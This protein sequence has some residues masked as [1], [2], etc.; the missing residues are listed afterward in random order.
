MADSD[1]SAP[2]TAG[3][4]GAQ[5]P[6]V[7]TVRARALVAGLASS[8]VPM[9]IREWWSGGIRLMFD[10]QAGAVDERWATI[11]AGVLITFKAM[12]N[13]QPR[14]VTIH[15]RIRKRDQNVIEAELLAIDTEA[16]AALQSLGTVKEPAAPAAPPAKKAVPAAPEM[17]ADAIAALCLAAVRQ[18]IPRVVSAY[19][20]GL[21]DSL[22]RLQ[23]NGP[24]AQEHKRYSVLLLEFERTRTHLEHA[25]LA[26]ALPGVAAYLSDEQAASG[27]ML[28]SGLS[29]L[30]SID[31]RATLLVTEAVEQVATRLRTVWYELDQ[32][33]D[34]LVPEHKDANA[35]APAIFCHH[36]RDAIFFD[37]QAGALRQIDLAAGFSD[38]FVARLEK[39]YRD[40]IELLDRHGVGAGAGPATSRARDHGADSTR[41]GRK[42]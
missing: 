20:D 29:L 2:H 5:Q 9:I 35:L 23:T 12:F 26:E 24:S 25:I 17:T 36:F 6:G 41:P 22:R 28:T 42:R 32:R 30:E 15:G 7:H 33:L 3:R 13:N 39:L 40:L 14:R 1:H 38:E 8:V 19:L 27:G 34:Q 10:G 21:A 18:Q 4:P 11:G 37:Q 31:L 16:L